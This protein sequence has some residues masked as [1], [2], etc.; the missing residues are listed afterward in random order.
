A[1][2]KSFEIAEDRSMGGDR[3]LHDKRILRQYLINF[4]AQPAGIDSR[5]LLHRQRLFSPSLAALLVPSAPSLDASLALLDERFIA[6]DPL[7]DCLHERTQG[8]HDLA[9]HTHVRL[10]SPVRRIGPQWIVVYDN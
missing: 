8:A 10:V 6:R 1:W 9:G 2:L 3:F 7:F 4:V 5:T